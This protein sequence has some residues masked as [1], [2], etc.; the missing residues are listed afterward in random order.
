[1]PLIFPVSHTSLPTPVKVSSG[2]T[3]A[4][5]G[6]DDVSLEYVEVDEN[7]LNREVEHWPK[8]SRYLK[9]GR[10]TCSLIGE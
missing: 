9:Q 5:D 6:A 2:V 7:S 10:C 4:W 3:A 1:M 8:E